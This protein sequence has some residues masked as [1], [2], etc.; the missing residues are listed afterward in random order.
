MTR[1]EFQSL[2]ASWCQDTTL[3]TSA[4]TQLKDDIEFLE[5]NLFGDYRPTSQGAHL[6]FG[7]RLA[8]WIGNCTTDADRRT[9]FLIFKHLF[10]ISRDNFDSAYRTAYSKCIIS[11][12]IGCTNV[13]VFEADA[14]AQI[15]SSLSKLVYTQIT[16]S[17]RLVDFIHLNGLH[18]Q[19][20][21]TWEEHKEGWLCADFCDRRLRR[22][23]ANEKKF[24]VLFEDFV[25]SGSQMLTAVKNAVSI[26]HE[27]PDLQVLLCPLFIC[28]VG[29]RLATRLAAQH[30]CLTYLPV[31][32]FE[33]KFFVRPKPVNREYSDFASFR[34]LVKRVDPLVSTGVQDF[35]PF[36]YRNT[37]ALIVK[38]DNTPDNSL[39]IIHRR[40]PG[41]WEPVFF[42]TSREPI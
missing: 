20:R 32:A 12:L 4:L 42:R 26:V 24:L 9:L 6:A 35:G 5:G 30:P 21:Y 37:G 19:T 34:E 1:P 41:T 13:N 8:K 38:H 40:R 36:G 22:G 31:L 23:H 39:P 25:G 15:E 29:H 2:L 28:P 33:R 16:D 3:D 17:F 11:W 27:I 10:F 7:D 18:G 14:A